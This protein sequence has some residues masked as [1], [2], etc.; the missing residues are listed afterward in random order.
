MMLT[1]DPQ[2]LSDLKIYFADENLISGIKTSIACQ[3]LLEVYKTFVNYIAEKVKNQI[4]PQEPTPFNVRAM[5]IEGL[6]KLRHV[7]AWAVRSVVLHLRKYVH[8][9]ISSHIST[10][11]SSVMAHYKMIELVEENVLANIAN[12]QEVSKYKETLVITEELQFRNRGLSHIEDKGFEFILRLEEIRIATMIQRKLA[13]FKETM[14]DSALTV[15]SEDQ[16]LNCLWKK[17]FPDELVQDR[18][19]QESLQRLFLLILTKYM[20]A[21]AGQFLKDFRNAQ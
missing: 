17:C 9:N 15:A 18:E 16:E 3:L 19:N 14:I 21:G 4:N 6:A 1:R 12:L 7:G 10:T 11:R 2:Y 20:K 8:D 5:P 13:E